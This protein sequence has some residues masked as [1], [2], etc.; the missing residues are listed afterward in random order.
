MLFLPVSPNPAKNTS[1]FATGLLCVW[2]LWGGFP[3]EGVC[4]QVSQSVVQQQ[5]PMATIVDRSAEFKV[6]AVYLYNFARS[7]EWP[8]HP[9]LPSDVFRIAVVGDS[10]V[11]DYLVSIG[12]RRKITNRRTG[13]QQTLETRE[14]LS[15]DDVAVCHLLFI[16]EKVPPADAERLL[17]KFSKTPAL[18][19]GETDGFANAEGEAELLLINGGVRFNLNLPAINTKQLKV[20]AKLLKAANHIYDGSSLSALSKN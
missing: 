16:S 11:T 5:T 14:Y 10:Q 1:R 9:D 4:Q 17:Q 3:A 15:P 20:D 7:I 19:V 8:E 6:K 18:V 2:I 12:S 13:K